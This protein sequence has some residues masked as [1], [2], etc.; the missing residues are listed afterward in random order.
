MVLHR[1]VIVRRLR[2]SGEIGGFGDRE[3]VQ[4]LVEVIQRRGGDA[5]GAQPEIDLVE[6]KLEDAVLAD[7]ALDAQRQ[8]G[9]LRLPLDRDFVGQQEI[10]G[11]LLGNGRRSAR[12]PVLGE[13]AHIVDDG[14]GEAEEVDARMAVEILVL[15][16]KERLDDPAGHGFDRHENA[17]LAGIFAEQASIAGMNAGHHRR[18][19]I[20]ELLVVGQPA[21]E[22]VQSPKDAAN[23]DQA[24]E[25][26]SRKQDQNPAHA[27]IKA[28][29]C[30]AMQLRDTRTVSLSM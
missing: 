22:M 14:L 1:M 15:G 2:Q 27:R 6:I 8:N 4:A 13:V 11:N 19:V 23:R 16:R 30:A 9:F 29:G 25:Q 20:G 7:G 10:L 5:V 26:N 12:T 18:L 24:A 28:S 3:F 21:T 17:P